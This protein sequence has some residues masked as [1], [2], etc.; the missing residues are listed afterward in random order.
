MA[1][2]T[3]YKTKTD[4]STLANNRRDGV[5]VGASASQSVDLGLIPL[6]ESYRKT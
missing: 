4:C 1:Y 2:K 3:K 6:V 5:V